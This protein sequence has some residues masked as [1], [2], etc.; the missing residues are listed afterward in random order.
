[1]AIDGLETSIRKKAAR[2]MMTILQE[3]VPEMLL[4]IIFIVLEKSNDLCSWS[5]EAVVEGIDL[6]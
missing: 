3:S 5:G 6:I 2:E 4:Q 1:M